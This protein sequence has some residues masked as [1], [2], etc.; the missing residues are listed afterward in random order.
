MPR[1]VVERFYSACI[2]SGSAGAPTPEDLAR[3][4]PYLSD[5]LKVL[6]AAARRRYQAESA[7][8]SAE[9][10]AFADGDLFSSLFEGPSTAAVEG[11]DSSGGTRRVTVRLGYSGATP[12]VTWTDT[13]IVTREHGRFVIDDIR[14][15]AAWDFASRGTL[16]AML[17]ESPDG[18]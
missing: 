4:S 13:V 10:P 16:R 3:L 8:S 18:E 17:S 11:E 1:D 12:A 14:Y 15:G 5:T 2:A 6:L 9:K 7:R